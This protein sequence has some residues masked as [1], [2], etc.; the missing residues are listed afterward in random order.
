M[1]QDELLA[2]LKVDLQLTTSA[3]DSYLRVLLESAE[4]QI[5]REGISLTA[6][7]D[8]MQLRIMYAAYLYRSR[9]DPEAAM[10][11]M[12]RYALNNRLLSQ[13]GADDATG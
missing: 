13:K 11:R 12:L 1:K 10:P 7:A 4:L 3:F 6:S 2:L 9:A 8:D 5:Q